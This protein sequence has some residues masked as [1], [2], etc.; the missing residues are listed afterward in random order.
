MKKTKSVLKWQNNFLKEMWKIDRNIRYQHEARLVEIRKY[1]ENS[2][3]IEKEEMIKLLN[4]TP[5][6]EI[7]PIF[8][9]NLINSMFEVDEK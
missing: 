1:V 5:T 8:V 2:K 6:I 9:D 4:D 3:K 7:K